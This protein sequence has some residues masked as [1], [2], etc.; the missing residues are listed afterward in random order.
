[1]LIGELLVVVEANLGKHKNR[2]EFIEGKLLIGNR[3]K[4]EVY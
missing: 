4:Q 2:E 1:V 3:E